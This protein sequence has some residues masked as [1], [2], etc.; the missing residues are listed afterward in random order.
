MNSSINP[1][2]ALSEREKQVGA[3]FSA[4]QTYREISRSLRPFISENTVRTH[5]SAIYRKLGVHNKVALAKLF[6]NRT[7]EQD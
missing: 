1:L 3:M 2:S 4:G 6:G 5:L 7:P